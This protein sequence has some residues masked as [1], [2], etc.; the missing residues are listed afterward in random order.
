MRFEKQPAGRDVALDDRVRPG[1][2]IG[3]EPR[4]SWSIFVRPYPRRS[5]YGRNRKSRRPKRAR[6]SRRQSWLCA[7][8]NSLAAYSHETHSV[9]TGIAIMTGD[10]HLRCARYRPRLDSCRSVPRLIPVRFFRGSP[11]GAGSRSECIRIH[12]MNGLDLAADRDAR[13]TADDHPMLGSMMMQLQ[14]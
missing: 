11:N 4:L 6:H 14:R 3:T 1:S 5:R 13:G 9:R 8:R 2:K 10:S 12:S 7:C